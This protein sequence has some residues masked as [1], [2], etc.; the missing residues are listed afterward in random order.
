[1]ANR[2]SSTAQSVHGTDPQL[3]IETTFRQRIYDSVY[4]KD[5]C[6]GLTITGVMEKSTS[7]SS[8]GGCFGASRKPT[9]FLCLLLKL[10]QLQPTLPMLHELINQKDFK[11]L[12]ALAILYFRLTQASVDIYQ[13][14]EPLYEDF[15]KLRMRGDGGEFEIVRMDE[16]VD[17]LLREKQACFV[18]LPVLTRRMALED[19]GQ[20]APRIS[21]LDENSDSE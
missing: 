11:Y 16:F 18:T 20:L 8:V 4:W 15:S 1:M 14:L 21:P 10:L 2:T 5:Q 9:D 19:T 6:F 12:R 13:T 7:I 3:L 17:T